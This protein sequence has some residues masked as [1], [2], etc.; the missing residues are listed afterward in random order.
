[1]HRRALLKSAAASALLPC[2][3]TALP[4]AAAIASRV[5]PGDSAWPDDAAWE[6]LRQAV[7]GRLV[8]PVALTAPCE[9]DPKASA[10]TDLFKELANPY[11]V[12]DQ[13]GGTQVS[14]W[15]DA[16]KPGLS[17]WAVKADNTA[18]VVAA[19]NFARK[20]NLRLVVKGG[21]HSYQGTSNAADSLLVWTRSMNTV[22]LHDAFV[23]KGCEGKVAPV[24]AVS[25]GAGAMWAD[26]YGAVTSQ[27]G[28]Y[29][30]GGG[31]ANVGVAGLIQSGGFGSFS[32]RYGLAA[33][34]LIEA[35]VVTADGMARVVNA[36]QDPELLW[37]LKGGGG[38]TFGVVTRLT[39]KTHDLAD[40]AGGF[41]A[42]FKATSDAAFRRLVGA[43]VDLIPT[44]LINPHWG[45][46]V[47][48]RPFNT[49]SVSMVF[50]GLTGAQAKAAWKPLVD[51]AAASPADFTVEGPSAASQP[52]RDWWNFAA[53]RDP[54]PPTSSSTPA[55]T[56]RPSTAGG[57]AIPN[58]SACSS[59]AMTASGCPPLS[60][61]RISARAWLTRSSTPAGISAWRCTSTRAWPAPPTRSSPPPGTRRPTR[62]CWTPLP[63][64]SSRPVGF[65]TIPGTLRPTSRPPSVT[66]PASRRP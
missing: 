11:Y 33:A 56:R 3:L 59:T 51:F 9:T 49:I 27:A 40:I 20:H 25:I 18:D 5:R 8:K 57:P 66:R 35:E 37:A 24:P 22:T 30:Q 43:F 54:T 39:L 32:K 50:Q 6:G 13:P 65:P 52:M 38:G 17:V 31:C 58:R 47:Q 42:T 7:G 41:D 19:V 64:S 44:A 34:S 14:G 61:R 12:G 15:L 45:E 53:L 29:V 60:W 16:W 26:A 4:A 55:R 21:G 48:I 23:P 36:S 2:V 46:S 62:R 10:C 63:L 28:R 1:M